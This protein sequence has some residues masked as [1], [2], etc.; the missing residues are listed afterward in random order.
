MNLIDFISATAEY[1]VK[2]SPNEFADKADAMADLDDGID[3]LRSEGR[4]VGF[5]IIGPYIL[6]RVFDSD[7]FEEIFLSKK[8]SSFTLFEEEEVCGAFRWVP[9]IA[10][11]DPWDDDDEDY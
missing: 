6:N 1:M 5:C 9:E 4:S 10:L 11:S 3:L 2:N 7:G 8:L